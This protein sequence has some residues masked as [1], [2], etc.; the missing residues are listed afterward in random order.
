[1]SY[2]FLLRIFYM[3][4]FHILISYQKFLSAN[5]IMN[6]TLDQN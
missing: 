3:N 6:K 5:N 2:V 1:L 4:E